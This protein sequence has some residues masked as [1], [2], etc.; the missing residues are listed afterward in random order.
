MYLRK[1]KELEKALK[2]RQNDSYNKF[3]DSF[4]NEELSNFDDI[5]D[6]DIEEI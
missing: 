3:V 6:I 2:K 4:V 1:I 5:T